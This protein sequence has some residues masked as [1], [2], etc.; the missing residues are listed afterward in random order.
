MGKAVSHTTI[1]LDGFI[2][3]PQD[4]VAGTSNQMKASSGRYWPRM[5]TG[6]VSTWCF[7]VQQERCDGS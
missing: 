2:A 1:S 7:W 5:S 6:W 4:G 3:G